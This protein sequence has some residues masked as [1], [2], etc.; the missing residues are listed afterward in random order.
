M[1]GL[2]LV[3][4]VSLIMVLASYPFQILSNYSDLKGKSILG[5]GL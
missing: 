3:I 1:C 5:F 2:R 4:T